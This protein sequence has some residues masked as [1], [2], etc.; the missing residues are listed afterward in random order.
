MVHFWCSHSHCWCFWVSTGISMGA[1][2]GLQLFSPIPIKLW[3]TV[4]SDT[5]Q[6]EPAWTFCRVWVTAAHLLGRTTQTSLH[7][8]LAV[9][10][11]CQWPWLVHYCSFLGPLLIDTDHCRLG[12]SHKTCSIRDAPT[13]STLSNFLKSSDL[14]I[15]S[16][17]PN[18]LTDQLW[19]LNVHL[20]SDIYHSLT[21]GMMKSSC[22]CWWTLISKTL[23]RFV[24]CKNR[25]IMYY[26]FTLDLNSL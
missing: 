15:F 16:A 24:I 7:S 9:S 12:I 10:L 26:S 17:N 21:C 20:L 22:W 18:R 5:F 23:N 8:P 6:S 25:I 2:T 1:L 3:Y 13:E 19:W 4:Y 11:G 14:H